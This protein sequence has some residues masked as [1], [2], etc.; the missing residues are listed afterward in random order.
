MQS[1]LWPESEF[2]VAKP[3]LLIMP[4][5]GHN[6]QNVCQWRGLQIIIFLPSRESHKTIVIALLG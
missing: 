1:S 5:K 2:F 6:Q 3:V 4:N